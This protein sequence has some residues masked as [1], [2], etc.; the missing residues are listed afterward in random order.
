MPKS[1]HDYWSRYRIFMRKAFCKNHGVGGFTCI[2]T[3]LS[4]IHDTI[5]RNTNVAFTQDKRKL[6][7]QKK[8][9]LHQ[10]HIKEYQP[11]LGET[12]Q[13]EK[14]TPAHAHPIHAM[15]NEHEMFTRQDYDMVQN[16]PDPR[17]DYSSEPHTRCHMAGLD[18][19]IDLITG[20]QARASVIHFNGTT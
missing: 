8:Q 1:P 7:P 5:Y 16:E 17:L 14:N 20:D 18:R 3:Y 11:G 4:L 13:K 2:D 9:L 10:I 12:L 19:T 6:L 15:A